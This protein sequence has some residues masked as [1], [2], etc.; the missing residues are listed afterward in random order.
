MND[1]R[2]L[3][4]WK[5][6]FNFSFD[7]YQLCKKLP[8]T[9]R[10]TL[11]DQMR[12]AALSIPSNIAEGKGRMSD[13]ELRRFCLIA[14]GSAMEVQTQIL[15]CQKLQIVPDEIIRDLLVKNESVLKL[16]NRFIHCLRRQP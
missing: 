13:N 7:V 14:Y 9:E 1:Y 12:R 15:F 5:V 3:E 6:S 10:F 11:G 16:L 4:V 8:P 2:Q